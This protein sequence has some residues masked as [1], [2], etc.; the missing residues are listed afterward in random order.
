MDIKPPK[1]TPK[2]NWTR[3]QQKAGEI[4]FAGEDFTKF[5]K[6]KK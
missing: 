6:P 4:F 5:K 3:Q 2:R 1:P